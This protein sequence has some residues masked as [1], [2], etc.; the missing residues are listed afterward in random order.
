[1]YTL[2]GRREASGSG[3]SLALVLPHCGYKPTR[4]ESNALRA[5]MRPVLHHTTSASFARNFACLASH[6]T[7]KAI[8]V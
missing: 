4:D 3:L 5:G 1:M 6:R 2:K 7:L 8:G